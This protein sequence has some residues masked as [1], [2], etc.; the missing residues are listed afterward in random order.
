MYILYYVQY[1]NLCTVFE[2]GTFKRTAERKTRLKGG[3]SLSNGVSV[4]LFRHVSAS[5]VAQLIINARAVC[6]ALCNGH[7]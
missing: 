3:S 2:E 1:E 5:R 4:S 7:V 6:T